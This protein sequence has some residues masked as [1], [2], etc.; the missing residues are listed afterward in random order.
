MIFDIIFTYNMFVFLGNF[1]DTHN[2]EMLF[3]PGRGESF[4]H[5]GEAILHLEGNGPVV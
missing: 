5:F 4:S 1:T 2:K 3:L